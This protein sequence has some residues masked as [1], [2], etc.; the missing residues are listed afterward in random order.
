MIRCEICHDVSRHKRGCPYYKPTSPLRCCSI[1]ED[2][3]ETGD[4]YIQ[5]QD[6]EFAH[7]H[8]F[9]DADELASWFGINIQI[10]E[11]EDYFL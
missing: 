9:Y 8:C 1:C 4:K 6:G 3:I 7:L 2:V 5:N 10:M 11:D